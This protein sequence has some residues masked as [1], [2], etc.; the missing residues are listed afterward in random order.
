M[1]VDA[2]RNGWNGLWENTRLAMDNRAT[3]AVGISGF[4]VA[5]WTFTTL[6]P[7]TAAVVMGTT[8]FVHSYFPNKFFGVYDNILRLKP[9]KVSLSRN[10]S[11]LIVIGGQLLA[12]SFLLPRAQVIAFVAICRLLAASVFISCE[13]LRNGY[14]LLNS[15]AQPPT[16]A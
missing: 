2:I 16:Q 12:A 3:L 11:S 9:E 7:I 1:A 6:N 4:L 15:P 5:K 13:A 10:I 14:T 8:S